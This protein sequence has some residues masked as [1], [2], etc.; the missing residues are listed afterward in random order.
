[1]PLYGAHTRPENFSR[2]LPLSYWVSA[3]IRLAPSAEATHPGRTRTGN[4]G[5]CTAFPEPFPGADPGSTS[6]PRTCGRRSERHG[7]GCWTRTNMT[8]AKKSRPA[9]ERIPMEPPP[10]ASPGSPSLQGTAG[11]WTQRLVLLP[12]DVLAVV[13][14]VHEQSHACPAPDPAI[15]LPAHS[16][17]FPPFCLTGMQSRASLADL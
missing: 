9:I 16:A 5:Y 7:W 14:P 10:G 13:D 6:L 17:F 12:L 8:T 2:T 3:P 1:M 4:H 11:R 15:E